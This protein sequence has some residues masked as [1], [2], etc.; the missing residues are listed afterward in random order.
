MS[1]RE[2]EV[3]NYLA[4]G[5]TTNDIAN[6]LHRSAK[7]IEKHRSNLLRKLECKNVADLIRIANL[8]GWIR[9][10]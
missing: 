6:I 3:L 10:K 2:Q 7:T 4:E 5:H 9:S 1:K 8:A